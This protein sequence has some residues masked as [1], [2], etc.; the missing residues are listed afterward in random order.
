MR[1]LAFYNR[2]PGASAGVPLSGV[3]LAG[4]DPK[5]GMSAHAYLQWLVGFLHSQRSLY[6]A[7]SVTTTWP[8]GKAVV[9]IKFALPNLF[10]L[11]N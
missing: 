11:L 10:G 1:V 4:S 8:H 6:R 7:A 2:G 5:A 9:S 3:K